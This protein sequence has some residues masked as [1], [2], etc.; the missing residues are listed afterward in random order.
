MR[1]KISTDDIVALLQLPKVG[2]KTAQKLIRGISGTVS[3]QH[4]L[5]DYV[6]EKSVEFRLPL[7]TA[8]DFSEAY[9]TAEMIR[10]Q[11]DK[12]GIKIIS[13]LEPQYPAQLRDLPDMPVTLSYKGD[14]DT[15]SEKPNVA[16]IGTRDP[17]EFGA[18][19]GERFGET[20]AE[21]AFN[22]VSGLAQGCDTAGHVGA[23]KGKGTTTA[24]LAHGLDSI[25]PQANKGLAT[26]IVEKG[27]LLIS[28]YFV[29]Q[30]ALT[31]FFVERDRIQA[32]LSQTVVVVETDV[33]GGT[34]HT[35]R[36][37]QEYHRKLVCFDHPPQ[38]RG[39]AKIEGNQKL[40]RE[41]AA[42]P[43][44]GKEEIEMLCFL[45]LSDFLERKDGNFET[46]LFAE[47]VA[48]Y[49][50]NGMDWMIADDLIIQAKGVSLAPY[51]HVYADLFKR[52]VRK[53]WH[54]QAFARFSAD[55]I[56]P[57]DEF[58]QHMG[59]QRTIGQEFAK[60]LYDNFIHFSAEGHK[61][62]ES[63]KPAVPSTVAET[64]NP[65]PAPADQHPEPMASEP[66]KRGRKKKAETTPAEKTPK[67][68]S[69]KKKSSERPAPKKL[70]NKKAA[71]KT[72]G[73][74]VPKKSTPKRGKNGTNF[75]LWEE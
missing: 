12:A 51:R 4:E 18:R 27:G 7:Y 5:T 22:V 2:R 14:I 62:F 57:F 19:V 73:D 9:K 29:K 10:D 45:V 37:S 46:A 55:H 33:K 44:T 59:K 16:V 47:N 38:H 58:S 1:E 48:P 21:F 67:K 60:E 25:Y 74:P 36:Y 17:S 70:S 11:S 63:L 68:K 15:L 56:V 50:D 42:V 52:T 40:I 6:R 66:K 69:T 28:E 43:V 32:G 54:P 53:D 64:V 61:Y 39:H 72:A 23:L 41:G 31:N 71:A 3:G 24:V 35:V 13:F 20:F 75:K 30:K 34:M 65:L 8:A 49:F 26:E